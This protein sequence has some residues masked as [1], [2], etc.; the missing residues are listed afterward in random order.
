[1]ETK[2]ENEPRYMTQE[3]VA[4]LFRVSNVKSYTRCSGVRKGMLIPTLT[5]RSE[6]QGLPSRKPLGMN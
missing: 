6:G 4:Q 2:N 1:M 5:N 3:E